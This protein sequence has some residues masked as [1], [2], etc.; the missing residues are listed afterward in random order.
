MAFNDCGFQVGE[1][2]TISASVRDSAQQQERLEL[3]LQLVLAALTR[4]EHHKRQPLPLEH[5]I[6]DGLRRLLLVTS[7][8]QPGSVL[9]ESIE[10]TEQSCQ[11]ARHPSSLLAD[12]CQLTPNSQP[13]SACACFSACSSRRSKSSPACSSS[14]CA[15]N[16]LARRAAAAL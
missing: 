11:I 13:L 15:F 6:Q 14:F 12:R 5:R 3:R 8:P 9:A 10:V 2:L 4:E 7:Q 1:T 16:R